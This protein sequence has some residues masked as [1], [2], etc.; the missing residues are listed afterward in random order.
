MSVLFTNGCSFTVGHELKDPSR[1]DRWSNLVARELGMFDCNEAK[2]GGSNQRIQRT[3]INAI[4]QG[5]NYIEKRKDVRIK[6]KTYKNNAKVDFLDNR[7]EVGREKP[8]LAVIMWTGVNRWEHLNGAREHSIY[9]GAF[10]Y[11]WQNVNWNEMTYDK[12]TLLPS[13]KSEVKWDPWVHPSFR[14]AG[15]EFMMM[16]N[17]VW[18]L[19]DTIN[20]MLAVKY[21]LQA[22]DIPQMHYVWHKQHYW[23]I[24]EALNTEVWEAANVLWPALDLNKEQVLKELPFLKEEGFFE[25]CK[26]NGYPLGKLGHPLEEGHKAMAE[27]VLKDYEALQ[28]VSD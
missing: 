24:L 21:F 23:T 28:K 2:I 18:A 27:R 20:N 10:P 17:L 11:H 12:K 19:K 14:K 15:T 3:T 8:A 25:M 16:R 1:V 4:L 7:F 13:L 22:Q 6:S 9:K 26:K 5:V